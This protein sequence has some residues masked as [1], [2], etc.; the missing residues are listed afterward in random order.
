MGG[1]SRI[2]RAAIVVAVRA[3]SI[4]AGTGEARAPVADPTAKDFQ[5]GVGVFG[6][7]PE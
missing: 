6:V 3:L 1:A 4:G 2:S 7:N 5:P